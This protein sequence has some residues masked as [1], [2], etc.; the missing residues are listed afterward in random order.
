M[1]NKLFAVLLAF[2]VAGCA[3]QRMPFPEREYADL[4]LRGDKT[5][6]GT[7]FLVDQFEERQ[8]GDGSEV[9]LEPLT[10]YSE[11]WYEVSY[12]QGKTIEE[13]DPRYS[14]YVMRTEADEEGNFSFEKVGAGEYLLTAPVYWTAVTCS[15][16]KVDTKVM[17]GK[18]I[19]VAENDS[20]VEVPLTK[21]YESPMVICD[22]YNQG[23]W[24]KEDGL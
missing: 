4:E 14:R 18:K 24:E 16:A 1:R 13:P 17:I 10:S 12:R 5:V 11:Q 2:L 3:A 23:D 9:T 19:T 22:L 21:E 15:A 20:V 8:V 6:K 7:V